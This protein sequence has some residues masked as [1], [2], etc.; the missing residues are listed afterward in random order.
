MRR[1]VI[2]GRARGALDEYAA[3]CAFCT[4]DDV[5]VV[6]AMAVDF[7]DRI[8]H[9]V[10][11]HAE[12]FCLWAEKRTAAGYPPAANY[13]GAIYRGRRLGENVKVPA[14]LRY[15]ECVGGSSG[16]MAVQT[17]LDALGVA[18]VV[19]AGVPMDAA[20]AHYGDAQPWDEADKYWG[21]WLEH[22][23][24]LRGRVRSMSGRTRDSLGFP[25]KE[26]LLNE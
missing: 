24:R 14:P 18:R 19:L 13:W 5:L 3:A 15:V 12:L 11:F 25:D 26:W 22:M 10:S 8:D 6:G 20:A 16:F 4:F 2:V 1:A 23:D 7:P 21:T 9:L 17:A